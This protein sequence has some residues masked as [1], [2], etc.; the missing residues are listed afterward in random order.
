MA[1]KYTKVTFL[2]YSKEAQIKVFK[3]TLPT[4]FRGGGIYWNFKVFWVFMPFIFPLYILCLS[5]FFY[6]S[7]NEVLQ[8]KNYIYFLYFTILLNYKFNPLDNS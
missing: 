7:L 2:S 3:K 5:L 4:S 6:S 8:N 1:I